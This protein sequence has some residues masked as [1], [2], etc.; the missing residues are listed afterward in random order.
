[1]TKTRVLLADDHSLFREGLA[2]ILNAQ[3]DF[4]VVGEASDGL[5][6][7]VKAQELKPDLILM[8]IAMPGG[9][10]LEATQRIKAAL[11][12]VTIVMLTVQSESEKLFEAIKNGAQGYILKSVRSTQ[13][14]EML[15]GAVRGEAAITPL[16]GGR[17]LEEFRRLSQLAPE[18]PTPADEAVALTQRE[19]EV[20]SLVAEGAADKEIAEALSL[21]VHT[22]KSHIR[23]ILA[24]IQ[25]NHRHEAALYAVREGLIDPPPKKKSPASEPAAPQPRWS[26]FPPASLRIYRN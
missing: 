25:Q 6:V 11:P 8:D 18:N 12:G 3:P 22:V 21:S 26:R 4:E 24:K 2:T 7:L 5:E 23:N 19:Q 20:L 14:M 9:D 10:G 17:I 1:M 15:R 16:L 13:L